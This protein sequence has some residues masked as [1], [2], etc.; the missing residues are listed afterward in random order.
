[1]LLWFNNTDYCIELHNHWEKIRSQNWSDQSKDL[2]R[3]FLKMISP[4]DRKLVEGIRIDRF[5]VH[6]GC[7]FFICD[8]YEDQII[9]AFSN[10]N[11]QEL[12]RKFT[13]N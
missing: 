1:M 6:E 5:E 8:E 11:V 13:G 12:V 2:Y 3:Y 7:I 10:T 9:V 4:E